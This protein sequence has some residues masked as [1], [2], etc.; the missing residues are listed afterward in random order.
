M[1]G[2]RARKTTGGA[3]ARLTY[4][5]LTQQVAGDFTRYF[6]E[7]G[8]YFDFFG[9]L[10]GPIVDYSLRWIDDHPGQPLEIFFLPP[11][12]NVYFQGLAR[13]DPAFGPPGPTTAGTRAS[14]PP[15]SCA[16]SRSRRC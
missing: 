9:R 12:V 8:N 4:D 14:T 3:L 5:H 16:G 2:S 6:V 1:P 13:Y 11:T 7:H 15:R 10:A